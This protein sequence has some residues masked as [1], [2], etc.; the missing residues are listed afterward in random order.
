[1]KLLDG[2][3]PDLPVARAH[4]PPA[5]WYLDPELAALE[6]RAVFGRSWQL[7]CRAD[8]VAVPGAFVAGR[9]GSLP[10]VVV[11]DG[12]GRL[13]AH[14]NVCRHKAT[15]VCAGRGVLPPDARHLTCPYHGW[16]YRLDGSLRT[17]PRLAGIE[18]FDRDAMGLPPLGVAVW[19]PLVLVHR[20]PSAPPP[21]L[22]PLTA[23]LEATGW[24]SLVWCGRRTWEIA[25]NWKVFCDNYLDGGYHVPHLHPGL[26][27]QLDLE[28]Y[29]TALAEGYSVQSCG[30]SA[31]RT[32]GGALYAFVY[33]NLML[34]RYGPCLDTNLVLPL[35]PGRARVVFDFWFTAERAADTAW[36]GASI[37]DSARTQQEDVDV[38]ERV[39]VGLA[40][41]TWR[42]GRY[43]P[44][45]EG[46]IHHFHRMLAADLRRARPG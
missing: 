14:A 34:N 27:G 12:D 17:A 43:A 28:S 8:E 36:V 2:F 26:A 19:G 7:A 31:D 20:D 5:S 41:G 23:A 22:G 3:D 11:R 32:E 10:W 38:S 45:L 33:P 42:T 15:E 18:A 13:R 16:T 25:C 39:Q 21:A 6:D 24:G 37:A 30:A 29:R 40:S 44:Q 1:M 46:A 4:T 35:S 9:S